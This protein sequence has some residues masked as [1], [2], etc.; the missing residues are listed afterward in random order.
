VLQFPWSLVL[1]ARPL[2]KLRLGHIFNGE[3]RMKPADPTPFVAVYV[4]IV[5]LVPWLIFAASILRNLQYA[6]KSG[7]HLLSFDASAQIRALRQ[8]D[9]YA[10]ALHRRTIKWLVIVL[11]IWLIGFAVLALTLFLLHRQGIV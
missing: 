5:F 7:I 4:L 6:R 10:A 9:A 1:G 3:L 8:I 2:I 11:C